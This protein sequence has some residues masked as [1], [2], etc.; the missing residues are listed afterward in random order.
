MQYFLVECSDEN[1]DNIEL[2]YT[3]ISMLRGV[4]RVEYVVDDSFILQR[5]KSMRKDL[6]DAIKTVGGE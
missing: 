3:T 5:L 1:R 2:I 4:D 6:D